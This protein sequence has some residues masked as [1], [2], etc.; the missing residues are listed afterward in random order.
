MG[1]NLSVVISQGAYNS[2]ISPQGASGSSKLTKRG[3]S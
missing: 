2:A 1:G 3:N